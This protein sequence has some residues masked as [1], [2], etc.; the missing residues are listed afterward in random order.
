MNTNVQ[1]FTSTSVMTQHDCLYLFSHRPKHDHVVLMFSQPLFGT[2]SFYDRVFL[3]MS[4]F[5]SK[6]SHCFEYRTKIVLA[7]TKLIPAQKYQES[8]SVIKR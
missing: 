7:N 5:A 2:M 6:R 4:F 3:N 8:A 1:S